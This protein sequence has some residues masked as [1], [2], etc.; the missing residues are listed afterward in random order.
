M[1]IFEKFQ[2]NLYDYLCEFD[3]HAELLILL[4]NNL[5]ANGGKESYPIT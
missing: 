2:G 5:K 4:R 3:I 1:V